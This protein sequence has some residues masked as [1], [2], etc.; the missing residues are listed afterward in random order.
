MFLQV[1]LQR[2]V[3]VG[4]DELEHRA[5]HAEPDRGHR[6]RTM[7]LVDHLVLEH[8][9]EVGEGRR[10]VGHR[11][12]V[13]AQSGESERMLVTPVLRRLHRPVEELVVLVEG[14]VEEL[15][16]DAVAVGGVRVHGD[17]E[18]TG[19]AN[20][21]GGERLPD[22]SHVVDVVLDP[23][24]VGP[25]ARVQEE[26]VRHEDLEQRPA[27]LHETRVPRRLEPVEHHD[28]TEELPVV[29]DRRVVVLVDDVE[30]LDTECSD[31]VRHRP[32]VP[33]AEGRRSLP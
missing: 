19:D 30:V 27:D 16:R 7:R 18:V 1:S 14:V 17:V 4:R 9:P 10:Q 33:Q 29:L 23:E 26:L 20:A 21:S 22:R 28:A 3:A 13:A 32:S 6:R 24:V 15:E 2:T 12:R 31:R 11:H 25:V 8:G 5:A